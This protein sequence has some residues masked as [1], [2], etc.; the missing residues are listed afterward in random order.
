VVTS[1]TTTV[2]VESRSTATS[3]RTRTCKLHCFVS[4]V[5]CVHSERTIQQ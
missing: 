3:S 2:P 1:P 4:C 5:R